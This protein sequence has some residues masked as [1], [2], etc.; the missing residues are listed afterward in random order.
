MT[1]MLSIFMS[2]SYCSGDSHASSS[3]FIENTVVEYF[4]MTFW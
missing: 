2:L 3:I 1:S 4:F